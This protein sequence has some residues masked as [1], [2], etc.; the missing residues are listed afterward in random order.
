[1]ELDVSGFSSRWNGDWAAR[2]RASGAWPDRTVAD[3]AEERATR[4]PGRVLLVD[5]SRA[6]TAAELYDQALRLAAYLES[7]GVKAGDVVSF[8]LPNWHE[9][10]VINLAAAM[11]GAVVNPIVPIM[12]ATEVAFMLADCRSRLIFTPGT[13]R[14]F[15]Y[16]TMN[17]SVAEGLPLAPRVVVVRPDD[18]AHDSFAAILARTPPL[19]NR[20]RVSADA[21]KLVMFTSGTTGRPKAVLHTHNTIHAENAKTMVAAG[22]TDRDVMFN[23]SP[24]THV[25]GALY[26]LNLPWFGGLTLVLQDLWD[27]GEAFDRL[28]QYQCTYMA[29]AT[30]FLQDLIRVSRD[31][32]RV[33]TALRR[34]TCG[35]AGVPASLIRDARDAFPNAQ[36]WRAFG[37]TECPT[38]TV[39]P[40]DP[41]DLRHA[42]ETDGRIWRAEVK[43]VDPTTGASTPEGVEGEIL[44]R[45]DNM[46]VGYAR[47]EDNVEAYD[48]EGFFRTG[49]LGRIVDGIYV[50]VT[51]R[52]KDLIIRAGENISA[53]E[54]ED[55]LC[56][57]P[58]ILDVAVVGM[59][60]ARTGEAIC[61]VV[62]L[63]AGIE[64][65]LA[66]VSGIIH[67][68][69]LARQKSPEHI[70]YLEALPRT[71][72]GKVRKDVLRAQVAGAAL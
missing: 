56:V 40:E 65:S 68:A 48:E 41:Q 13:Y 7:V 17:R 24:V 3:F 59:P 71:A 18:D 38:I 39:A 46:A 42:S 47:E 57:D 60:S 23:P 27:A 43:I 50:V 2:A 9:A 1:M 21:I 29:G 64:L 12:R 19:Q 52:R 54:I 67:Q 14:G 31:R 22:L 62:V 28:A 15:D 34:F 45:A 61:A 63:R 69:G 30:P 37:A 8:Q 26:G 72:A 4:D 70:L 58:R 36:V 35:G 32:G 16:L 10:N 66:D 53:K 5:G 25:T 33:L 55:V 6:F 49:D 44:A 51:G 11:V 20:C